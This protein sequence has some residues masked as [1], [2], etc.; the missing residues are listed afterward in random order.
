MFAPRNVK[1]VLTPLL[2]KRACRRRLCI[3]VHVQLGHRD[4]RSRDNSIVD[5]CLRRTA[6]QRYNHREKGRRTARNDG[7]R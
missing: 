1:I 4:T 7:E 2:A 3:H 5:C 6:W